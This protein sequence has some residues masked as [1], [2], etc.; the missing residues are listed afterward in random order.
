MIKIISFWKERREQKARKQAIAEHRKMWNWIADETE[1]TGRGVAK[2]DY[3]AQQGLNTYLPH[4]CFLCAYSEKQA[5]EY[6]GTTISKCAFCP[7]DWSNTSDCPCVYQYSLVQGRD[8][9]YSQ[10]ERT[11]DIPLRVELARRIAELPE[12]DIY[13]GNKGG[14]PPAKSPQG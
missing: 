3:L 14:T 6:S 5:R 7:L 4:D 1:R 12:R 11:R 10:W 13:N 8:G 2:H 9:L